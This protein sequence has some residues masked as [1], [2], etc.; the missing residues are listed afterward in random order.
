MDF[1]RAE[2]FFLEHAGYCYDPK[3][4]TREEGRAR[5]ARELA[6]AE[7]I[8]RVSGVLFEW[9]IDPDGSS[10]DWI[11]EG[12]DGGPDCDPWEVWSCALYDHEGA[13]LDSLHGIDF[14]RDGHPHGEPYARVVQANLALEHF[15]DELDTIV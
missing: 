5:C 4:E 15:A 11:N 3:R 12:E 6:R 7:H 9:G 1:T 8:A 14:G 2:A 13:H 10:A